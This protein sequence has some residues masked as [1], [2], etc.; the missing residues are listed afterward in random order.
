[1]R[2][3]NIILDHLIETTPWVASREFDVREMTTSHIEGTLEYISTKRKFHNLDLETWIAI[4]H[5]ELE[6]REEAK[7]IAAIVEEQ[8]RLAKEN[9]AKR[10]AK[11]KEFKLLCEKADELKQEMSNLNK[12]IA[13]FDFS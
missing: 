12:Q 4:F 6:L 1:M 3:P 10:L 7:R 8:E 11:E 9:E 13:E 5:R 2:I